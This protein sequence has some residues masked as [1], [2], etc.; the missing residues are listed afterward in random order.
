MKKNHLMATFKPAKYKQFHHEVKVDKHGNRIGFGAPVN[1]NTIIQ[2]LKSENVNRMNLVSRGTVL[3]MFSED[4]ETD[5]PAPVRLKESI[6]KQQRNLSMPNLQKVQDVLVD[7][8]A[9]K[10]SNPALPLIHNVREG[11]TTPG[12]VGEEAYAN[13]YKKYKR[14]NREKE[15]SPNGYSA[16]TA[17][18]TS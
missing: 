11:L 12:Y 13:F 18:L 14:I 8:K 10:V 17:Y 1:Y 5:T 4:N 16:T 7:Q 2:D 6:L 15:I 9:R 3:K